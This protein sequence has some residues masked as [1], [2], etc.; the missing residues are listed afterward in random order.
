MKLPE[1]KEFDGAIIAPN[2]IRHKETAEYVTQKLKDSKIPAVSIDVDIPG[3][4]RVGVSTYEA[5]AEIVEHLI[6]AHGCKEIYYIAGPLINPEGKK[7]YQAYC[8]TL[9]R[10]G[11]EYKE[12]HVYYGDFNIAGGRLAAQKFL[13]DGGCP[14]A[15]VCANDDTAMGFIEYIEEKGY[16]VPEDVRVT[17][18]DDA[19]FSKINTPP[20]TTVNKNQIECGYRAVYEVLALIEGKPVEKHLIPCKMKL[21]KSCGCPDCNEIEL[22]ELKKRYRDDRILTQRSADMIRNMASR[23]SGFAFSMQPSKSKM[24]PPPGMQSS[25]S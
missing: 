17:G 19:E 1:F 6:E 25:S 18:F 21:R 14:E 20:L 23:F 7:R 5:Q 11:L 4:S 10:Y 8:D 15:V 12:D 9:E 16:K 2:I 24:Y 13:N 3:M 22:E